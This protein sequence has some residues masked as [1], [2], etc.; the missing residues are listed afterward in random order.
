[1]FQ[2][3]TLPPCV[4]IVP[5]NVCTYTQCTATLSSSTSHTA[6]HQGAAHMVDLIGAGRIK[7]SSR[8]VGLCA[9]LCRFHVMSDEKCC[10]S[11]SIIDIPIRTLHS[12]VPLAIGL[13]LCLLHQSLGPLTSGRMGVSRQPLYTKHLPS[14][15]A[16]VPT[17]TSPNSHSPAQTIPARRARDVVL[18]AL[19]AEDPP[20]TRAQSLPSTT[21]WTH[22]IPAVTGIDGVNRG[23]TT[24]A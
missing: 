17:Y 9:S 1:M 14:P 15:P 21:A 22:P 12:P 5:P 24:T 23:S 7:G 13:P 8:C 4:C 20:H 6:C 11:S 16:H 10:C 18:A 19:A 3:D 2:D